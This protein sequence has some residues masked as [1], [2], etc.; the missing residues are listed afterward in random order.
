M[1]KNTHGPRLSCMYT[2]ACIWINLWAQECSSHPSGLAISYVYTHSV[3]CPKLEHCQW[4]HRVHNAQEPIWRVDL[5]P[6]TSL[7]SPQEAGDWITVTIS[8]RQA[9]QRSL[10]APVRL[11]YRHAG[12][13]ISS[14]LGCLILSILLTAVSLLLHSQTVRARDLKF[15]NFVAFLT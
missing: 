11:L 4:H 1:Q 10:T 3:L 15:W 13:A 9:Q 8:S 7:P 5:L 14:S 2:A 12:K 6:P